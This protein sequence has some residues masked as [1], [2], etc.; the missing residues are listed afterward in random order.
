MALF[1][2]Y[3]TLYGGWFAASLPAGESYHIAPAFPEAFLDLRRL[4]AYSGVPIYWMTIAFFFARFFDYPPYIAKAPRDRSQPTAIA[5]RLPDTIG[6]P[7]R[8]GF[9][10]LVPLHLGDELISLSSEDH[11]VRVVTSRGNT[12]IRY[13]F[14]EALNEVRDLPGLQVHRSHW[15]SIAA[16]TR[17]S[18]S[19][20]GYKLVLR[21]LTE[22]PVSRTNIGLLRA[23]GLT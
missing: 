22:V 1:S 6:F 4:I 19:G 3:V 17:V 20:N 23:S 14:S 18:P 2:P 5:E 13:R 10:A 16:I 8:V 12:L 9:R 15:V 11:Y 7:A 21:D